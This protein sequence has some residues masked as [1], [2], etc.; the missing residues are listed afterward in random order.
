MNVMNDET[1]KFSKFLNNLLRSKQA[2]AFVTAL[3]YIPPHVTSGAWLNLLATQI[4]TR[5]PTTGLSLEERTEML[6]AIFD[7]RLV[8]LNKSTL[9]N[10]AIENGNYDI[11][12]EL[13]HMNCRTTSTAELSLVRLL[14]EGKW[15]HP[16]IIHPHILSSANTTVFA[17]NTFKPYRKGE[18]HVLLVE[19]LTKVFQLPSNDDVDRGIQR[20]LCE[21]WSNL[22][23]EDAQAILGSPKL[24]PG[25]HML[26]EKGWLVPELILNDENKKML[27]MEYHQHLDN[28]TPHSIN[29]KKGLR[30]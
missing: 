20:C 7:S 18:P 10:N 28:Q 14:W 8:V 6:K 23:Q 4:V 30:L 26:L 22:K 5:R 27:V 15:P 24:T 13:H 2:R 12:P 25:I 19:H 11:I 1:K 29:K 9:M 3:Q 21:R 17:N 16:D